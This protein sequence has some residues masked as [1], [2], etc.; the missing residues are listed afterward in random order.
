MLLRILPGLC[1]VFPPDSHGLPTIKAHSL[2]TEAPPLLQSLLCLQQEDPGKPTIVAVIRTKHSGLAF[3]E[4]P[5]AGTTWPGMV[6]S[7]CQTGTFLIDATVA[8]EIMCALGAF[9]NIRLLICGH[10]CPK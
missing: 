4:M 5:L 2:Q 9:D 10:P 7:G 1:S 8:G 6:G 3:P